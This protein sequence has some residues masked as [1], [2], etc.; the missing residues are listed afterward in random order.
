MNILQHG[1]FALGCSYL[2]ISGQGLLCRA[3]FVLLRG[4]VALPQL[5]S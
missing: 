4:R 5:N 3:V 1:A 2:S